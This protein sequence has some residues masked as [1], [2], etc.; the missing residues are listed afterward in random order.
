V[1][2]N[3]RYVDSNQKYIQYWATEAT[4]IFGLDVRYDTVRK[5]IRNGNVCLQSP[6]PGMAM[7][8]VAHSCMENAILSN[9]NLCQRNGDT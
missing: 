6:V 2:S 8:D 5:M 1:N 9:K 4:K 7:G 3:Q